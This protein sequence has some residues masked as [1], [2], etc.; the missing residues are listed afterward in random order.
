MLSWSSPAD[1]THAEALFSKFAGYHEDALRSTGFEGRQG[2]EAGREKTREEEDEEWRGRY[3]SEAAERIR[4]TVEMWWG[5]YE[6]LRG[7]RVV[8]EE[9]EAYVLEGGGAEEVRVEDG[10][11]IGR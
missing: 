6:Y 11:L 8:P 9:L 5:D 7:F 2:G 1:Q 3:G 4:Q 10:G